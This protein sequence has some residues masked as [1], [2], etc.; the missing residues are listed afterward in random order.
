QQLGLDGLARADAHQ[1]QLTGELARRELFQQQF[2]GR[3]G[4]RC[5][6]AA[7][8]PAVIVGASAV[9][10]IG[11][12]IGILRRGGAGGGR[13]RRGQGQQVTS[14]HEGSVPC[15]LPEKRA[16]GEVAGADRD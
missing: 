12:G 15:P 5:R 9:G 14:V 3:R 10:G 4:L 11:G 6:R 16:P 13:G 8:L 2:G 7:L 1:H